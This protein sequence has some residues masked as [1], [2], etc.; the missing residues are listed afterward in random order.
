MLTMSAAPLAR[1]SSATSGALMRFVV[2]R[3]IDTSPFIFFVTHAIAA[4]ARDHAIAR[5]L[6]HQR[7]HRVRRLPHRARVS[8]MAP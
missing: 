7:R 1:I 8:I 2:T 3:G 5:R 6:N 4:R